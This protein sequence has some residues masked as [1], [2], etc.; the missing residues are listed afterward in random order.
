MNHIK[1]HSVQMTSLQSQYMLCPPLAQ[2]CYIWLLHQR[3]W[4]VT[5]RETASTI[6]GLRR[7]ST[8]RQSE[9]VS[10][11]TA[12]TRQTSLLW[13]ST[14]T[15]A[16]TCK[17]PMVQ[18]S[19]GL[20]PAKLETSLVQRWVKIHSAEKRWPYTCLQMPEWEVRKELHPWGGQFRRRKWDVISYAEKLNWCT[21]TASLTPLDTETRCW[22]HTCCPQWTSVRKY[23]STTTL[24]RTQL[25]LL[26]TF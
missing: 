18:Q 9:T 3:N 7:I 5:A 24:G 10:M 8:V 19:K 11:K 23:F 20:G 26:L 22:H 15:T 21:I 16:S 17:D 6:P 1:V 13:H 12:G 14:E 25:V 2:D 4:T